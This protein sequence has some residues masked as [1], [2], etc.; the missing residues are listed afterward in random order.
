MVAIYVRDLVIYY[1][2]RNATAVLFVPGSRVAS[3]VISLHLSTARALRGEY[4]ANLL[5]L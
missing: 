1:T 4:H 2:V 5:S 3:A